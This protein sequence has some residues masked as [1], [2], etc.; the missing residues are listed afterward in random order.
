MLG[1]PASAGLGV[2][3]PPSSQS[4]DRVRRSLTCDVQ[5]FQSVHMTKRQQGTL[6]PTL[7]RTCRVLANRV[8]LRMLGVLFARGEL[9]V[10]ALA[11]T[12]GVSTALASVYLRALGARGLLAARRDGPWVFYR[13]TADP[14]VRGA[15]ELSQAIGKAFA[16]RPGQAETI[17]RQATAFTHPRRLRIV[18]TLAR[19]AMTTEVL[20]RRTAINRFALRRH[21]AKLVR[22][23][24]VKETAGTWRLARPREPLA[25]TLLRLACE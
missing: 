13:P 2:P 5:T 19:G 21:L 17:F 1:V 24:F 7:W 10:S 15:A 4:L 16:R 11:D 14:S 25:A 6:S 22:R 18:Q 3:D 9:P 12:V 8:R 23:G 20:A